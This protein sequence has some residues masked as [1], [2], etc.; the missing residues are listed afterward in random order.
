MTPNPVTQATREQ[1]E[2]AVRA[3]EE[4][5][6]RTAAATPRYGR[7]PPPPARTR[8]KTSE[9]FEIQDLD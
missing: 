6:S 8:T 5:R 1:V 4:A 9:A 2:R 7:P 3:V